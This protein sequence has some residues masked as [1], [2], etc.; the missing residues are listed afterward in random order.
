M[1]AIWAHK[2]SWPFKKP[3]DAIKLKL[4][5]YHT[6]IKQPMDFGTIKKR[7]NNKYYWSAMECIDDF[8]LVFRNCVIYNK[9]DQDIVLMSK[10]LEKL[11]GTKL[12][13]MMENEQDMDELKATVKKRKK[14]H[15]E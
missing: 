4:P 3:V 10:A 5:H 7:L 8:R 11:F 12:E 1:S 9:P 14:A 2:H 13:L 6:I 15:S